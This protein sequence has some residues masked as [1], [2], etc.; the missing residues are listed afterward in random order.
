MSINGRAHCRGAASEIAAEAPQLQQ[1]SE[2]HRIITTPRPV[3]SDDQ[4]RPA[5]EST[6]VGLREHLETQLRVFSQQALRVAGE[7]REQAVQAAIEAGRAEGRAQAEG[8]VAHIRAAAQKHAEE[9]KR[10]AEAQIAELRKSLEELRAHAQ[11]QLD[12]ARRAAQTEVQQARVERDKARADL[13]T[14]AAEISKAHADIDTVR[15]EADWAHAKAEA[16][17]AE[18]GVARSEGDAARAEAEAARAEREAAGAEAEVARADRDAARAEAEVARADAAAARSEAEA[19]AADAHAS[20]T[21]AEAARADSR[22]A[23]ADAQSALAEVEVARTAADANAEEKI[24]EVVERA[25]RVAYQS[26]LSRMARLLRA[27]RSLDGARGISSVLDGLVQCAGQEVD[28]AA[29][30]VV[31]GERLIGWRLEGFAADSPPAK[32]IDLIVDEAGLAGVVLQ[33]GVATSRLFHADDGPVSPMFAGNTTGRDTMALPVVVGGE[34]VAVLYADAPCVD[35]V[36]ADPQWPATLEV[37]VRHGSRVL[38]AI[39]LLQ[40]AGLALPEP[41]ARG[42]HMAIPTAVEHA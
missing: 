5:P 4:I 30:L 24:A 32:S 26:E 9:V 42:S 14:T 11:Q 13:E 28:R 6:A 19:A 25:R 15:G 40:A 27:L 33:T 18:A 3:S 39:T 35:G 36:A 20:R 41:M 38:E 16:A 10:A 37:L 22:V 21:E 17:R 2:T 8:Q 7:E 23:R 29:M 12:A 1:F 34:V 31:K